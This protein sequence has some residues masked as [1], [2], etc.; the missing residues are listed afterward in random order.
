MI[1][2]RRMYWRRASIQDGQAFR[3]T[4]WRHCYETVFPR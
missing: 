2:T 1:I 4:W 3:S